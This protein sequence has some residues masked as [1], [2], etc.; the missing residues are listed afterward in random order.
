VELRRGIQI[1]L[2]LAGVIVL[3]FGLG[4]KDKLPSFRLLPTPAP[5]D[6]TRGYLSQRTMPDSLALIPPPPAEGSAA[7]LRDEE[8]RQAALKLHGTPR[9]T[10]AV[11]DSDRSQEST[12]KAFQCAFGTA[13]TKQDTPSLQRLLAQVRVDVRASSYLAKGRYKRPRPYVLHGTHPCAPNGEM[14]VQDD[15]SY[16]SARGAVGWAYALVLAEINPARSDVIMQ[17]GREFGQSRVICDAEWQSDVDASYL[18]A[19]AAV[20]RM[21][22]NHAFLA[23]FRA[24]QK[25]LAQTISS[26]RNSKL[27]CASETQALAT[28]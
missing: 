27:D 17:R 19:A 22:K 16:P 2:A 18:V 9:Y 21:H 20:E 10:L 4:A 5:A 11:M 23:D 24:A 3:G 15:G 8:L 26:E 25:E 13:I 28:R 14:L 6:R 1:G 7:M 12:L